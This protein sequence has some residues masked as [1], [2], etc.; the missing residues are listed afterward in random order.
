MNILNTLKRTIKRA[1]DI[2]RTP[3]NYRWV[4]LILWAY[5]YLFIV[6]NV[7]W[8]WMWFALGKVVL[9]DLIALGTL[10]CSPAA[11][12]ALLMFLK[13]KTDKDGNKIPDFLEGKNES[14]R[15][16]RVEGESQSGGSTRPNQRGNRQD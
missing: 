12:A 3:K 10:M 9:S 14:N 2:G 15:C 13:I 7:A 1:I 16:E 8:L 4:N 6:Y 5:V 11:M